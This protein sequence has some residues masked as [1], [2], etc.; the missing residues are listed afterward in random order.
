M[1]RLLPILVLA[2]G[3]GA[4]ASELRSAR[5]A[6]YDAEFAVVWNAVVEEISKRYP[7][8]AAEDAVKGVMVTTWR[9]I[10]VLDPSQTSEGTSTGN[11][12]V[13]SGTATR[14]QFTTCLMPTHVFRISALVRGRTRRGPWHVTIDGEAAE[15]QP[16][17]AVLVPFKHGL[18]DEPAW[19]AP[20]IEAVTMAIHNRLKKHALT[21]KDLPKD[22][23]ATKV[24][25]DASWSSV[26]D[27]EAVA[28]IGRVHQAAT[29]R[30]TAALRAT[31]AD[32]F[33]Y[34]AGAEGS[35]DTVVMLWA[36]DT[37][38]M[39]DLA[40]AIDAGCGRDGDGAICP[41]AG[42][43]V[44]A[45]FAKVDGAWKFVSYLAQ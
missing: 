10:E 41:V 16:G 40:R 24:H 37:T 34:S 12:D 13:T 26:G 22:A 11:N 6:E 36:A 8:V 31:M 42:E 28:L 38:K 44:K 14:G 7:S 43:G 33:V 23:I 45:R 30:D 9:T 2:A 39:R 35:A 21:I 1:R 4:T 19:V 3:C 15:C 18:P 5:S 27:K 25:D 29:R 32:N 17:M 20:R